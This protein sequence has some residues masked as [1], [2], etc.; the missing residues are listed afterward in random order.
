MGISALATL[1]ENRE[2]SSRGPLRVLGIDLGTTN[3]AI[4]EI[5]VP[6]AGDP[7]PEARC[8]DVEQ[9]TLLGPQFHTLVPSAVALHQGQLYVGAGAKDLRARVGDRKF[10]LA[11]NRNIFWDCKNDIGVRRT[12]HRAPN[13]FRSAREIAGHLLRFLANSAADAHRPSV[14]AIS[15]TVPASFQAAQRKDTLEAARLAGIGLPAGALVDEPIAA[16]VDYWS[17]HGKDIFAGMSEAR[18]LLVFDFGGGTLDVALF[19]LRPPESGGAAGVEA[20]PLSVS[21]Y[22]RLGGGDIDRAIV[23]E[24]LIPQIAEQNGL[25]AGDLDYRTRS[26]RLIPALLGC[27][28]ALKIGLCREIARLKRFGRYE[29][30]RRRLVQKNPGVYS[31]SLRGRTA[32]RLRS[33]TLS[34]DQ[35][36]RVLKP[37]LER[38]PLLLDHRETDYFTTCSVFAPLTDALNRAHLD[39]EDVDYCLLVGGSSLVPQVSEA[40]DA[41]FTEAEILRFDDPERAQATVA[42]GAAWQALSLAV[43][44]EGLVRPITADSISIQTQT[45]PVEL[46]GNGIQLPFPS[47]GGWAANDRLSVPKSSLVGEVELRVELRGAN[48][49]VLGREIWAIPPPVTKGDPLRLCCRMDANQVLHLRLA[50]GGENATGEEFRHAFENPLTSVVNPNAKRD[51]IAELEEHMRTAAL[52]MAGQ[53]RVVVEIAEL[54]AELGRHERALGL[55]AELN[56]ASP[57]ASM[58]HRMGILAGNMGNHELQEKLYREA[59]RISPD[60]TDSLFNLALSQKQQGRSTE[61]MRTIDEAL[62][63]RPIPH[64]LVLKAMLAEQLKRPAK[65]RKALLARAFEVFDPLSTLG[66]FELVWYKSG[67]L[68]AGDRAKERAARKRIEESGKPAPPDD[69]SE[70]P[71]DA[72][73][74]PGRRLW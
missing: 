29:E 7:A 11:Q 14:A 23:V 49:R 70:L 45:G 60:R 72:S 73:R 53:R 31:C 30:E 34:A 18:H 57:D 54:D 2:R 69:R 74:S 5:V 44:G 24:V 61:A 37:F 63:R 9:K 4:A 66:D 59:S 51:R 67:A 68:L 33:P 16:F 55:L 42:R 48:D 8:L 27:A 19:E 58:L 15:V 39:P 13:G 62:A 38:D 28:E 71:I 52:S 35:F 25:Q 21:R 6:T 20:A 32:L 56:R 1:A 43:Q 10:G 40:V 46:I 36:D 50:L 22:H 3:S 65:E 12:Y 41:F 64:G 17:T 47:D 26:E